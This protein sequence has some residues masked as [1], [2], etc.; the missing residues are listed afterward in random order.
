MTPL[1]PSDIA[2]PF[3]AYSHGVTCRAK[4]VLATSGQLG[5]A[6]DG[7]VKKVAVS[8]GFEEGE[9][10]ELRGVDGGPSPL[11]AGTRVVVLGA[12]ALTDGARVEIADRTESETGG[13]S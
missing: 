13:T 4:R 9:R 5:L 12:P 3:A 6:A 1:N 8:P 2:P 10:V 11:A 7:T